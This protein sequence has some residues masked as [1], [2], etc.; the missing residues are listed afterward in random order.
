MPFRAVRSSEPP[1]VQAL[2][3]GIGGDS[4]NE[5]CDFHLVSKRD[6]SRSRSWR[7]G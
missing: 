7:R 2:R 6:K 5:S 4:E 3:G 1:G